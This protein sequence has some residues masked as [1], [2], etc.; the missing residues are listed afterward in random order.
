[1]SESPSADSKV[2]FRVE[3]EGG[4]AHVETLWATHLGG[5]K[6]R[7]ENSPFW[8]YEVSWQDIVLAPFSDVEGHLT[9]QSVLAKSG[10]RTVR[11]S[12]DAPVED[13]N[14]S[15]KVLQ[16]LV[17]W[18]CTYEGMNRKYIS[19]NVPHG[20]ELDNVRDHLIRHNTTWEYADPSYAKL[21]PEDA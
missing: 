20:I 11:I 10:N 3:N 15:D 14:E 8:A 19:V 13:G 16:E 4:T 1:M 12:F 6:Y 5:D 21:F 18:G 17:A 7:L 2:L 9:F